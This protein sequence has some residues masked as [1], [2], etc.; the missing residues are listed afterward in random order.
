MA[1]QPDPPAQDTS[2][3]RRPKVTLAL[4]DGDLRRRLLEV[5]KGSD[6]D[7]EILQTEDVVDDAR[8]A[9]GDVVLVGQSQVETAD[10]DALG[11]I[12][13]DADEAGVAVIGEDDPGAR[14]RL[15]AAGFSTVLSGEQRGRDLAHSL[16]ALAGA[17]A[18]G[19][20]GGPE[21]GGSAVRPRLA[22]FLTRSP[23]MQEFVDLVQRVIPADTSLLILGPTGVGKEHLARAIHAESPRADGPFVSVNCAALPEPLLEAELFGHTSGAFTGAERARKGHFELANRGTV[24]LDEVGEMPL[25]LQAKLL[26]VLQRYEVTPIGSEQPVRV[27]VRVIVATNRDLQQDVADHRFREDLF[28]RLN[29]VPLRIPSL[30]E[31]PED[32]PDLVGRFIQHFR[33]AM[34][35]TQVKGISDAAVEVLMRYSWP[36]NLRELINVVERA[37]LLSRGPQISIDDLPAAVVQRDPRA[38]PNSRPPGSS[39]GDALPVGW[40]DLSIK[41]V[42]EAAVR[43]AESDYLRAVLTQTSGRV[44]DAAEI[45]GLSARA[46]YDKMKRYD[47]KKEDFKDP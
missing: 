29:V 35:V 36:G 45:A 11:D 17:E 3:K 14:A 16:E 25:H 1:S 41:E 10:V 47:L 40:T 42:R 26:T 13:R 43:R 4:R 15:L 6:V 8:K 31:R 28:Y 9:E 23:A 30:A 12:A 7:V 19:G 27:D 22:D 44:A 21:V 34:P 37:M 46:L 20:V 24:F 32:V 33:T 38:A 2:A 5:L 18:A 39:A